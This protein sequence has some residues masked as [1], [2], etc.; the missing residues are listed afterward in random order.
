[1]KTDTL[2]YQLFQSFH[3]LLFELIDRPISDAEGYQFSTAEIKEK[4]FRFDGIFIPTTNDKP[5]FFLEVQFQPKT[6]FYWEFLSEI[7]LYLNQFRPSNKWQAV[8]IFAKRNC[9]PEIVDH[10]QE[11]ITSNRII[12]V[13]LEDWLH[14]EADSFTIAIIQ[15]ILAPEKQTPDLARQINEKV[16]QELDT[17]LQDQVV[18]FIET[19]LVYKFPK[20]SRQEIEAM[21]TFNDLKNTRVYQDAKQEGKQEGLQ[22][23]KQEGLQRQVSMLLKM[24]TRK[25]GKLSPRTTNRITKLSVTQLENLAEV[26]FDLQTVADLNAWL[27]NN[28]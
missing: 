6:D 10:V 22:L 17:D 25:L 4:A 2:F 13:Y 3:T 28:G 1:M 12:R 16:Q 26:I 19:V 18:K 11:M 7:F 14:Q 21:F 24:L 20:L 9:E 8:A 15:L 23:G 27:R 5:I